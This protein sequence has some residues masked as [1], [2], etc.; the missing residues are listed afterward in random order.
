MSV[1]MD[2]TQS[3]GGKF[4]YSD[5][6]SGGKRRVEAQAKTKAAPEGGF[7]SKLKHQPLSW[8]RG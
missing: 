6:T 3:H 5:T 7:R 8:L 2:L 4:R 1:I